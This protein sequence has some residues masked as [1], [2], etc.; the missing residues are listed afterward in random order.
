MLLYVSWRC[1][2]ITIA[3]DIRYKALSL[4]SRIFKRLVGFAILLLLLVF[5]LLWLLLDTKPL[6]IS[7]ERIN[8]DVASLAEQV[9]QRSRRAYQRTYFELSSDEANALITIGRR[10]Y[11]EINARVNIAENQMLAAATIPVFGERLFLNVSTLVQSSEKE[12]AL[13][14]VQVGRAKLPG[15]MVLWWGEMTGNWYLRG[16]QASLVRQAIRQVIVQDNLLIVHYQWPEQFHVNA[17]LRK[18]DQLQP[19]GDPA[20][21]QHYYQLLASYPVMEAR[22]SLVT[23]LELLFRE[24]GI[25]T[26]NDVETSALE[27]NQ[28]AIL[29]LAVFLGGAEFEIVLGNL[30]GAMPVSPRRHQVTL[31]ERVDLQL[32]F[33]YSAA[34]KTLTNRDIG[35]LAGEMKELLDA[36]PGGSGFSF[37]DLLADKAGI[38]FAEAALASEASARYLQDALSQG[39]E[40][41]QILPDISSLPEHIH[42]DAFVADFEHVDS[43][44]YRAMLRQIES[45]LNALDLYHHSGSRAVLLD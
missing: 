24:A 13:D 17:L 44:A 16:Q 34:I 15:R 41:H 28:A 23:Y 26:A 40:E 21:M 14:Y 7:D 37:A 8:P 20:R 39:I 31:A 25:R 19:F 12:A 3:S 36:N 42:Y 33:V 1:S 32:H 4:R 5:G 38:R 45:A 6:V 35:F 10:L 27:E 18:R 43:V 2:I 9:L 11:P 29:A 30:R 22:V